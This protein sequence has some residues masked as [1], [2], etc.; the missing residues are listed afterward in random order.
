MCGG[1]FGSSVLR[2][3]IERLLFC[4][5]RIYPSKTPTIGIAQ[6]VFMD[7]EARHR[8]AVDLPVVSSGPTQPFHHLSISV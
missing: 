2:S 8:N 5:S 6:L 1:A 4:S 3:L 7:I